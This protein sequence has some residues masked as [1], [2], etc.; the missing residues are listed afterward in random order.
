MSKTE[1][2]QQ[3]T[4][5]VT[6][7]TRFSYLTVFEPKAID[8]G[9]E[10]KYSVSLI[11]SKDDTATI[12]KINKAVAAAMKAGLASKFGGKAPAKWRHPLRDG[13]EERPDDPAYENA[14]FMTASSKT[15]PGLVDKNLNKIID[16][17]D[18]YS[19][20]YG[21]ASVNF[22]AYATAG[23]KGI[24][25]GLNHLQKLSEGEPLGSITRAEDDFSEEADDDFLD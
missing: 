10:K 2:A 20:C 6:G 17:S 8:E 15:Q 12:D 18:L 19:G 14:Y 1:T 7:K 16:Q 9:G 13:D 24:A 3:T 11:I 4:K 23:N 22:Y 5:V 21:R 25:C